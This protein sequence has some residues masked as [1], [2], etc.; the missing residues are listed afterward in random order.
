MRMPAFRRALFFGRGFRIKNSGKLPRHTLHLCGLGATG[1][2][3]GS[4][5][6]VYLLTVL[7]AFASSTRPP[8]SSSDITPTFE[9]GEQ[10]S[11]YTRPRLTSTQMTPIAL[12]RVLPRCHSSPNV[13][14]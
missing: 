7:P 11:T 8:E 9:T 2:S 5:E 6:D 12:Y 4:R 1:D 14:S 13:Q 3:E 10:R